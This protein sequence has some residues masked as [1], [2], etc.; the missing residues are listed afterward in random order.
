VVA[1]ATG[2][3]WPFVGSPVF[4]SLATALET[5]SSGV[6]IVLFCPIVSEAIR[7]DWEAFSVDN[8]QWVV[9]E[10]ETISPT[11]YRIKDGVSETETNPGLYCPIWQHQPVQSSLV[12]LNLLSFS[13]VADVFSNVTGSMEPV[14]VSMTAE[15]PPFAI[16][17]EEDEETSW[18]IHPVI[19]TGEVVGLVVSVVSGPESIPS[20]SLLAETLLESM[21]E[22][23]TSIKSYLELVWPFVTNPV[24]SLV[25]TTFLDVIPGS[26]LAISCPLVFAENIADWEAFSVAN[27]GWIPTDATTVGESI[28]PFIFRYM[29]I[30]DDQIAVS[31]TALA[32]YCPVWQH[33]PV[34]TQYI[35]FNLLSLQDV[36][37]AYASVNSTLEPIAVPVTTDPFG[38]DLDENYFW[39]VRPVLSADDT[40]AGLVMGIVPGPTASGMASDAPTVPPTPAPTEAPTESFT[41]FPAESPTV[42]PTASPTQP[43]TGSPMLVPPVSP[44]TFHPTWSSSESDPTAV[45]SINPTPR[46]PPVN[47]QNSASPKTWTRRFWTVIATMALSMALA[48]AGARFNNSES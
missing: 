40:V 17:Q 28:T 11:I 33:E 3:T 4:G 41:E 44:I 29:E 43:P 42:S 8:Q 25:A 27:Q 36:A 15:T 21:S 35:N 37:D 18:L 24:F 39:M 5:T 32:P 1:A 7:L 10:E 30:G 48:D 16:M 13:D 34:S 2:T 23:M 9:N 14:Q 6:E 26:E 47:T 22:S 46:V 38:R 31:E 19:D 20:P 45:A 12:N